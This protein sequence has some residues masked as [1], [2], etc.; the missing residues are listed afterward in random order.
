M[1]EN[2]ARAVVHTYNPSYLKVEK[3]AVQAQQRQKRKMPPKGDIVVYPCH[4]S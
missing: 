4:P 2:Q 1:I 3:I